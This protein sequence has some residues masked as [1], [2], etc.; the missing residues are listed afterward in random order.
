MPGKVAGGD[1]SGIYLH[2][3]G[4]VLHVHIIGQLLNC[5]A[6]ALCFQPPHAVMKTTGHPA[7]RSPKYAQLKQAAK[8][9]DMYRVIG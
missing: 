8:P 9:F 6:S 5:K 1:L 4:L 2:N 3:G 7:Q